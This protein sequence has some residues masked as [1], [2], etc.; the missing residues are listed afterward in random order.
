MTRLTT[1]DARRGPHEAIPLS[2]I[3]SS[4]TAQTRTGYVALVGSPNA[5]KSTLLNQIIGEH[6]SIVTPKAQTTWQRVTGLLT[7]E[8]T[9]RLRPPGIRRLQSHR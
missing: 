7:I 1:Q 3:E 9:L 6:L 5:G 4:A 2:S 8:S